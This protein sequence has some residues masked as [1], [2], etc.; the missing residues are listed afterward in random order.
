MDEA[1]DGNLKGSELLD[2]ESVSQ[3]IKLHE[4]CSMAAA[5][6]ASHDVPYRRIQHGRSAAQADAAQRAHR[7]FA[8][9]VGIFL[10]RR[11]GVLQAAGLLI[12]ASLPCQRRSLSQEREK[13]GNDGKAMCL[14]SENLPKGHHA[15]GRGHARASRAYL[16][17]ISSPCKRAT[18]AT[19]R[20][21][22]PDSPFLPRSRFMNLTVRLRCWSR[23]ALQT[24]FKARVASYYDKS[25]KLLLRHRAFLGLAQSPEE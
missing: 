1:E 5:R 20:E 3:G 4:P 14:G 22:V 13:L 18:L 16:R 6:H 7:G 10:H 23:S 25:W 15:C 24:R 2:V 19:S 21:A 17:D 11:H 12:L 8:H 9:E